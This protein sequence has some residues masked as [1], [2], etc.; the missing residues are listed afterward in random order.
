MNSIVSLLASVALA[1]VAGIVGHH[2]RRREH[3]REQRLA[4]YSNLI[5]TFFS[6]T[7]AATDL[8]SHYMQTSD[9]VGA[10]PALAD[11]E[12]SAATNATQGELRRTA[13]TARYDFELASA[14]AS[15]VAGH[16]VLDL[17]TNMAAFLKT[18]AYSRPPWRPSADY[19]FGKLYPSEVEPAA[20]EVI[21]DFTPVAYRELWK[22]RGLM[23]LRRPVARS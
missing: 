9:P 16:E 6:A 18:A 8:L 11:P 3:L 21:A 22:S 10:T 2:L 1:L 17:V 12:R 19:V 7:R 23:R 20:T 4:A 14:T 15:M 5:A 13:A